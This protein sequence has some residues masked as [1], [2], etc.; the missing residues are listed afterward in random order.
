MIY[1]YVHKFTRTINVFCS[2]KIY[3]YIY[4]IY[5]ISQYHILLRIL[6]EPARILLKRNIPHMYE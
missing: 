5:M 4:D 3:I 6:Y 1:V 2:N